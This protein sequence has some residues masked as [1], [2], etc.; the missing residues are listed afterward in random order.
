MLTEL[1]RADLE[2]LDVVTDERT[3]EV[4]VRLVVS[5]YV[6]LLTWWLEHPTPASPE[7]M[8]EAFRALVLPGVAGFLGVAPGAILPRAGH[9][10]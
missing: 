8:D 4:A 5:A 6:G 9:R 2:Q 3:L 7:E 10:R 1:V